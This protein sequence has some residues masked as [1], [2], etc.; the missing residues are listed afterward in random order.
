MNSG[1]RLLFDQEEFHVKAHA[2]VRMA[3]GPDCRLV[4]P[5]SNGTIDSAIRLSHV[6]AA[7]A[8]KLCATMPRS[9][10]EPQ[11]L[12]EGRYFGTL[13]PDGVGLVCIG[14]T[15]VF[16]PTD[17]V[18]ALGNVCTHPDFQGRG[19]AKGLVYKLCSHLR[20]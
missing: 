17:G 14:G 19:L 2:H 12:D 1:L 13:H 4:T 8:A 5:T 11:V 10:F 20:T 16:A 9:W 15:H 6:H 3:L 7:A 18:A